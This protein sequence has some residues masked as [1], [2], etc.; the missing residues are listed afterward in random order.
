[1]LSAKLCLHYHGGDAFSSPGSFMEKKKIIR[2]NTYQRKKSDIIGEDLNYLKR[3]LAVKE[4]AICEL[5]EKL[6]Q[7]VTILDGSSDPIYSLNVQGEYT[8][9]NQ[10]FI[11]HAQKPREEIIGYKFDQV[12]SSAEAEKRKAALRWVIDKKE[13]KTIEVIT[14]FDD[15]SH[16]Y[17]TTMRPVLDI[18]NEIIL[19]VG[20]AKDITERKKMEDDLRFLST[21]DSLTGLFN[22]NFFETEIKRLQVSRLYPVS[23]V[24]CDLDHLKGINDR[25]GHIKGDYLIKK[26]AECLQ[27]AFRAEDIIAR[28]GGDEFAI[29]LPQVDEANALEGVSRLRK[30][31]HETNEPYPQLSIGVA[32]GTDGAQLSEV[33]KKAD[34]RMY[35]EKMNRRIRKI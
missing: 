9:V 20:T 22:R 34:D 8:Y 5:S 7:I 17:V 32:C 24:I 6:L 21:H 11:R 18:N 12:F 28:V 14:E 35:Q 19:V 23:I 27:N 26:T 29:L 30:L 1:M 25:F 13:P 2:S 10:A 15:G 16:Y 4:K 3:E 31:I 33:Q